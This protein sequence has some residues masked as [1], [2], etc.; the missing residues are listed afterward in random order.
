V[1]LLLVTQ[2]QKHRVHLVLAVMLLL[3]V[4]AT[5]TRHVVHKTVVHLV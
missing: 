5:S 2:K 1:L 3:G 4:I